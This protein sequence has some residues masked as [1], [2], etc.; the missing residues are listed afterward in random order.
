MR[1]GRWLPRLQ[2]GVT[3][4]RS[5]HDPGTV[6]G[7]M[8]EAVAYVFKP[9]ER[10]T[11]PGLPAGPGHPPAR[12]LDH[13]GECR[14]QFGLQSFVR[15]A[16]TAPADP[17]AHDLRVIWPRLCVLARGEPLPLVAVSERMRARQLGSASA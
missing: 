15:T 17:A 1:R 4:R 14:Q 12:R 9:H 10:P 2:H 6:Q 3:L 7:A 5:G 16:A 11:L 8:A 13:R